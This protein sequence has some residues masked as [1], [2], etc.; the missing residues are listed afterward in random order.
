MF[1]LEEI[2]VWKCAYENESKPQIALA[3]LFD[4]C[5]K[6]DVNV[7]LFGSNV[8]TMGVNKGSRNEYSLCVRNHRPARDPIVELKCRSWG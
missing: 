7:S 3:R 2:A 5:P 6:F 4:R 8:G 1:D